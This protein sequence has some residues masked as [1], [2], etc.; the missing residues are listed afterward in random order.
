MISSNRKFHITRSTHIVAD[1]GAGT[2]DDPVLIS[3][4]LE[5]STSIKCSSMVGEGEIKQEECLMVSIMPQQNDVS[6][7]F[8]LNVSEE[9][10]SSAD[11]DCIPGIALP[12]VIKVSW[13]PSTFFISLEQYQQLLFLQLYFFY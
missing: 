12:Q 11:R 1:T 5:A 13:I 4:L 7:I 6:H 10:C 9:Y 8:H 2:K 3:D